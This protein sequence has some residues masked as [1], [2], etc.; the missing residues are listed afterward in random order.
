MR[1]RKRTPVGMTTPVSGCTRPSPTVTTMPS[2]GF[3][4]SSVERKRPPLVD[5]SAL[6]SLISARLLVGVI[7]PGNGKLLRLYAMTTLVARRGI[8]AGPPSW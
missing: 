8:T 7:G 5:S 6:E 1:Q 4:T 2:R 3:S